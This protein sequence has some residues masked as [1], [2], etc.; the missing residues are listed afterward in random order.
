MSGTIRYASV[1]THR[2]LEQSRRDDLE[3]LFYCILQLAI[4]LLPW[5]C[6]RF[7]DPDVENAY[8]LKMKCDDVFMEEACS[9]M[10]ASSALIEHLRYCKGLSFE[11][12]P[13]YDHLRG[14]YSGLMQQHGYNCN[15]KFELSSCLEKS[16]LQLEGPDT[17]YACDRLSP[18][19][20]EQTS[21]MPEKYVT[22]DSDYESSPPG[23]SDAAQR[24]APEAVKEKAVNGQLRKVVV[25]VLYVDEW[26][27]LGAFTLL[28]ALVPRVIM[29]V[30]IIPLSENV[31]NNLCRK[32]NFCL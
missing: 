12:E 2:G 16:E 7:D 27:G 13:D 23:D 6:Q 11:A 28:C 17:L 15:T 21:D 25:F 24:Q 18:A 14:V 31:I 32:N 26:F 22:D 10:A 30:E 5:Q 1:N 9:G 20:P 3:C 29:D 4:G 8:T 19:Q